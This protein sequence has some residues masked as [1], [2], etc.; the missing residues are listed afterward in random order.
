M[1]SALSLLWHRT[2]ALLLCCSALPALAQD[3]PAARGKNCACG[4]C[5]AAVAEAPPGSADACTPVYQIRSLPP[6][7][8]MR[9]EDAAFDR[10]LDSNGAANACLV[11]LIA[12]EKIVR[13]PWECDPYKPDTFRLGDL[14]FGLLTELNP[15]A[16]EA[17]LPAELLQR[18][19]RDGFGVYYDWI[20]QPGHRAE[21]H[22]RSQAWL[23]Q[24][25]GA[26]R[27]QDN[28]RP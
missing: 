6:K 2:I 27:V 3:A 28:A 1:T 16:F 14:A 17:I 8:P 11:E 12:S 24:S 19:H 4:P 13:N 21:L 20:A 25:G 18:I 5:P 9:G 26:S 7:T 15:A 22:R 10:L 23:R